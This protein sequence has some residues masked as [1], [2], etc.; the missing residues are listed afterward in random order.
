MAATNVWGEAAAG[1]ITNAAPEGVTV[2][3]MLA[4]AA[5]LPKP[6]EAV[7]LIVSLAATESVSF[8]VARSP[9]TW[10][11]EPVTVRVVVPLPVI[12]FPFADNRPL[13]SLRTAVKVSPVVLPLSE[14][15]TPPIAV[16]LP[17]LTVAV[18]GAAMIGRPLVV[19]AMVA[20]VALLP[21]LSVAVTV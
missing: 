6:S 8:K 19:T 18:A 20:G 17:C 10:V 14:R 16:A 1:G 4:G 2:T 3:A 5:T 15:L 21:R 12:P 7:R 13:V 11:R 9:F